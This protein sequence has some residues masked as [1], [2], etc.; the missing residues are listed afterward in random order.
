MHDLVNSAER[1]NESL[2]LPVLVLIEPLT[3]TRTS[4]LNILRQEL[5][6]LEILDMATTQS[7]EC[8]ST[9]DVRLAALSIGDKPI[10]DPTVEDDLAAVAE[11]CPN[12]SIALV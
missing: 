8:T 10:D 3:L 7:L 5:A 6:S 4:I 2:Q 12:A 9:R 11:C 1:L